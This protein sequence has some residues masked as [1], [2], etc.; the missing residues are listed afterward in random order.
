MGALLAVLGLAGGASATGGSRGGGSAG[1][2]SDSGKDESTDIQLMQ[3]IFGP[4]LT[5]AGPK[6]KT[7]TVQA[8]HGGSI[9][10]L[11]QILRG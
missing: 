6:T 10:E 4:S 3:D 7:K 2:A 5:L 9:D 1:Q 11:L 8:A